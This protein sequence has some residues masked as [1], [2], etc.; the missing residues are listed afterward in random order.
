M[1]KIFLKIVLLIALVFSLH[2]GTMAQMLD[3][4]TTYELIKSGVDY[5]YNFQFENAKKIYTRLKQLY[6]EHPL[7][8][9]FRGL[10]TFWENYPLLADSPYRKSFEDDMNTTIRLCGEQSTPEHEA[11]FLMTNL[12]ARGMLLL[13]YADNSISGEVIPLAT[14]SFKYVKRAFDFKETYRD[15]YFVTGLYSYYREAYPQAHPIYRTIAFL[16]P[17]GDKEQGLIEL[18]LAARYAIFLKA[19]S[20]SFLS[21]IYISFENDFLKAS[22]FSEDLHNLYPENPLYIAIYIKNLL[23]IKEYDRAEEMIVQTRKGRQNDYLKVQLAIL[24]GILYEKKYHNLRAAKTYYK[25][26]IE[27]ALKYSDYANEYVAYAYFGLSRI[28][29]AE[30]DHQAARNYRRLALDNTAYDNVNF[31]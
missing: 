18:N 28:S 26:G 29:E 5:I 14:G 22:S 10:I 20:Y 2:T 27:K 19:E 4:T 9:L 25:S 7:P 17:G 16:F 12:A 31:D 11:E 13:F 3:D 23:L 21:G 8:F 1:N 30:N 15:F 24:N 6:P